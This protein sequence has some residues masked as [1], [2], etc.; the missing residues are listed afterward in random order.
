MSEPL[1]LR[2]LED[3]IPT[4]TLNRPHR[5]NAF[6]TSMAGEIVGGLSQAGHDDVV[7]AVIVTGAGDAFCA[8][9]DLA[10]GANTFNYDALRDDEDEIASPSARTTW[11]ITRI[12]MCA[13]S[14][15]SS[16]CGPIAASSR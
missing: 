13:I 16:H 10:L 12:P 15:G 11:S 2:E 1:G 6:T 5:L 8:G 3:G 4:V 7:R 9:V 14:A